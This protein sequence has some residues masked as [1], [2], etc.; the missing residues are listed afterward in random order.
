MP[1]NEN[2]LGAAGFSYET[3]LMWV[4]I[5]LAILFVALLV[6][7]VMK[8]RRR[9]GPRRRNDREG[10]WA[11]LRKPLRNVRDFHHAVMDMLHE[12]SRRKE[13]ERRRPP[14]TLL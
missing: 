3:I 6:A 11:G 9:A 14:G 13:L 10:L 5:G 12:R 4:A 8:L 2:V 7:D 1:A